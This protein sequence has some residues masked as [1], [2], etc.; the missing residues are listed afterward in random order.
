MSV[1]VGQVEPYRRPRHGSGGGELPERQ[2]LRAATLFAF[3]NRDGTIAGRLLDAGSIERR[4][5]IWMAVPESWRP[6]VR[7]RFVDVMRLRLEK[8]SLRERDAALAQIPEELRA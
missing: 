5:V 8:M 7:G 1:R 4:R 2:P 6:G 3:A